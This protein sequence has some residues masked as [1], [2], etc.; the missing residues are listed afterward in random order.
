MGCVKPEGTAESPRLV[1]VCWE[2]GAVLMSLSR[3][4]LMLWILSGHGILG[5]LCVVF[6]LR[7]RRVSVFCQMQGG[8]SNRISRDCRY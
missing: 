8:P 6:G 1:V 4:A 7:A 3:R 2:D 5:G